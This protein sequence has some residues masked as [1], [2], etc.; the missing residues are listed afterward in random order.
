MRNSSAEG[1]AMETIERINDFQLVDDIIG[2]SMWK[3]RSHGC[4]WKEGKKNDSAR[5]EKRAKN[6]V[7]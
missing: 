5:R 7:M 2:M 3:F 6:G 1:W 4:Q